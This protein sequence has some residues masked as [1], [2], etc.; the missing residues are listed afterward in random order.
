[1]YDIYAGYSIYMGMCCLEWV[2][3]EMAD[4]LSNTIIQ[5]SIPVAAPTQLAA[6]I[7][8]QF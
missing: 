8:P 5:H 3:V 2:V 6:G 4:E 1:M 7:T